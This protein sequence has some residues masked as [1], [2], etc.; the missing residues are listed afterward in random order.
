MK[1]ILSIAASV[2]SA[3]C[4]L[5]LPSCAD[6]GGEYSSMA[7]RY[8]IFNTVATLVVTADF[9]D[10]NNTDNLSA[11]NTEVSQ[12]LIELEN[13]LSTQVETS[14]VSQ[15]NSAEAGAVVEVDELTYT[16]L[17]LALEMYEKTEGYYNPA[18]YYSV[19]LF[20]FS[21][22][23][24]T[25]TYTADIST[26]M[27]YDRLTDDGSAVAGYKEPYEHYVQIFAELASYA[28]EIQLEERDGSYYVYK[29]DYTVQGL[30]GDTYTL[31]LDLGGI[32]KG[33]AA[34]IIDDIVSGYGFEY[35]YFSF[36]GSSYTVKQSYETDDGAW[37]LGFVNPDNSLA[38]YAVTYIS[39][40]AL[41][42]SG[43]YEKVYTSDTGETYCHIINPFTGRPKDIGIAACTVIGGDA[44]RDDA[45]TTALLVMG[46]EKAVEYINKNLKDYQ[47]I[48]IVR[49]ESGACQYVITNVENL[50]YD[51]TY[52]LANTIDQEGNIVLNKDYVA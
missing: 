32:G 24:N 38:S 11:L 17:S 26:A 28:G 40:T 23:F 14:Y 25:L 5:A 48:M 35:G 18:V 44:A 2:V 46:V 50:E 8:S 9:S 22:R 47:V 36:G 10:Q 3:A 52:T 6:S 34:D 7:A 30:Y 16:V 4:T 20:G 45:L 21:P 13:S 33:Y 51:Q 43:D 1:K 27:P 15:F 19:D 49:G 41:S 42:T 29:P 31:A 37:E 12:F 39:S